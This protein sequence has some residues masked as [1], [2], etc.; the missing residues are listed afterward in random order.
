MGATGQ[1]VA[2]PVPESAVERT[3]KPDGLIRG[4]PYRAATE[5]RR[6]SNGRL[7]SLRYPGCAELLDP[8]FLT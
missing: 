2:L 5:A 7:E 8:S 1:G 6:P 4:T 3:D